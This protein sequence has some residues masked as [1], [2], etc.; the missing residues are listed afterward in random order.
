LQTQQRPVLAQQQQ[1]KLSPRMLQAIRL[2]ALP[3]QE[4][5]EQIHQEL[6]E[7]PALELLAASGEVSLEVMEASSNTTKDIDAL[8]VASAAEAPRNTTGTPLSSRLSP[9]KNLCR[10]TF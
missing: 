4:L 10:N 9:P 2:L 6:E 8:G 7:N 1:L 5:T 3:L